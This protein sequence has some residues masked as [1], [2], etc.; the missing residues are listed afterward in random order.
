MRA[1]GTG[2]LSTIR[3]SLNTWI[4]IERAMT[5]M[6]QLTIWYH[7]PRTDRALTL[8]KVFGINN[9]K[10]RLTFIFLRQVTHLQ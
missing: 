4:Y 6:I 10:T 7:F 8:N 5:F 2:E 9:L 3:T 1:T